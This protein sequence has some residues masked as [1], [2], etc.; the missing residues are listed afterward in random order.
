MANLTGKRIIVTGATNGIGEVAALELAKMGADITLISRTESKLQA[1]AAKIEQAGGSADYITADLSS[2]E[3]TRQAAETFKQRHSRLDVLLNNAGAVFSD[4]HESVDGVEMTFALN[5][6]SYFLLTQDLLEILKQTAETH[7]EARVVN[8]SSSAHQSGMHWDDMLYEKGYNSFGAYGQSKAMNIL[9]TY[10]LDR[11]L[12]GTNVTANALHP[13][14]VETGFG[15]NN[16]WFMKTILNLLQPLLAKSADDGAKTSIYL[17]SSP[18]VAGV[19]GKYFVDE[20][21]KRSAD[22]THKE[23]SWERLWDYT[24]NLIR[25]KSSAAQPV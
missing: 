23:E 9:F 25:E 22:F 21:Q 20:K 19:S 1:T 17:A 8:V 4:R 5:H 10:E 12:Q 7:G 14:F 6:L 2:I 15:Q 11:R 24:E 16:G 18:Q 13:G 3:E